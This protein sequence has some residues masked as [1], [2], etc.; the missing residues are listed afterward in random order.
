MGFAVCKLFV[1]IYWWFAVRAGCRKLNPR[2]V[3]AMRR[4]SLTGKIEAA[5]MPTR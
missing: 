3:S 1:H 4:P 2:A 5:G